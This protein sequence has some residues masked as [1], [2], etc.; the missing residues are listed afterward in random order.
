METGTLTVADSD[1]AVLHLGD[2]SLVLSEGD[3]VLPEGAG[4]F[5]KYEVTVLPDIND[6]PFA[7]NADTHVLEQ[8]ISYYSHEVISEDDMMIDGE[9]VTFPHTVYVSEEGQELS[10]LIA[11]TEMDLD[12]LDYDIQRY[13]LSVLGD[14]DLPAQGMT[15]LA[16]GSF[17][18]TIIPVEGQYGS[19]WV[20][21]QNMFYILQTNASTGQP[22]W[23]GATLQDNGQ[24]VLKVSYDFPDIDIS[25]DR[26]SV[27]G[28][29]VEEP[30]GFEGEG[31]LVIYDDGWSHEPLDIAN[32]SDQYIFDEASE[33]YRVQVDSKY[34]LHYPLGESSFDSGRVSLDVVFDTAFSESL[35][36]YKVLSFI[37]NT[38]TED[39]PIYEEIGHLE[40]VED[41]MDFYY[42]G[43]TYNWR[44]EDRISFFKLD[45]WRTLDSGACLGTEWGSGA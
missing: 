43:T 7:E 21:D 5:Q 12:V 27:I 1:S 8:K 10:H 24:Y 6:I 2:V 42:G 3:Y 20:S 37:Q 39:V 30:F 15:Y 11:T 29:E 19:V 41:G 17:S 25:Q 35:P 38:G 13:G 22:E 28:F 34:S 36:Q 18:P 44:G 16:D 32:A 26:F 23:V 9:G 31:P 14:V 40:I 4:V 33:S 45:K